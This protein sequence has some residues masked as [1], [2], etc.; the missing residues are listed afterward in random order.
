MVP[1]PAPGLQIY[2]RPRVTLT[3]D[4]LYQGCWDTMGIRPIVIGFV[5]I[6]PIGLEIS[7]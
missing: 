1:S 6:R 7:G 2:I 3:F 5:K 4:I